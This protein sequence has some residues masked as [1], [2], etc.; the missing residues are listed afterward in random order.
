MRHAVE[1]LAEA[2]CYHWEVHRFDSWCSH[3][4]LMAS[5]SW[6]HHGVRV[7]SASKG[8]EYWGYL[9]GG[10]G[11]WYRVLTT[12]ITI[13]CQLYRI[14]ESPKGPSGPVIA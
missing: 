6:P 13:M 11:S 10:K 7:N 14:S 2:L 1:Q 3:W 5:F 9:L 8:N 12:C 4:D